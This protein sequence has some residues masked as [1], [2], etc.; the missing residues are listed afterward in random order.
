[1]S[2]SDSS[3]TSTIEP[4]IEKLPFY[5]PGQDTSSR[6]FLFVNKEGLIP[7]DLAGLI[8]RDLDE[9]TVAAAI[10]REKPRG[11]IFVMA[12]EGLL[13]ENAKARV[14]ELVSQRWA[15]VADSNLFDM[16]FQTVDLIDLERMGLV[17][18]EQ[19]KALDPQ[20]RWIH[21]SS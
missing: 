10:I 20:V 4:H 3:V 2:S 15:E 19:I 16:A 6:S 17:T 8:S 21:L 13:D 7:D 11:E 5:L 14:I 1:M 18:T 12:P 9:G